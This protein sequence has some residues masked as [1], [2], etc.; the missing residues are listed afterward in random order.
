MKFFIPLLYIFSLLL[1][2]GCSRPLYLQEVPLKFN[3]S[4]ELAENYLGMRLD[5]I[6]DDAIL[7][8]YEENITD[9]ELYLKEQ[10]AILLGVRPREIKNYPFYGFIDEWL[11]TPYAEEGFSSEGMGSA[12][13]IQAL[14][15]FVYKVS[16]PKK[17][18]EIFRSDKLEIFT[19]RTFMEEGDIIFFRYSKQNPISDVGL[20]LQ[21]GKILMSTLKDGLA[22]YDFSDEYFQLRYV[23]SGR[24][25]TQDK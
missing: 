10:Y 9:D 11:G 6:T 23:S 20:Y 25:R 8:D 24:L 5:D 15:S 13:F 7:S 2:A 17:P 21:N 1:V 18:N 22:I 19:G 16:L 12:A 3:Y 14:Y 4:K